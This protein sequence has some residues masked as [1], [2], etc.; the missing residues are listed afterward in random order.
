MLSGIVPLSLVPY[1]DLRTLTHTSR[2]GL[3]VTHHLLGGGVL[4]ADDR[5]AQSAECSELKDGESRR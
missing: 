3:L 4:S 1:T 5:D 2:E